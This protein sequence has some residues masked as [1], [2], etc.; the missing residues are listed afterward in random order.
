MHLCDPW[1]LPSACALRK[2][3]RNWFIWFFSSPLKDNFM[4]MKNA[5]KESFRGIQD[6][7]G[8]ELCSDVLSVMATVLCNLWVAWGTL[9]CAEQRG[10]EPET[11]SLLH[12]WPASP[13]ADPEM[14]SGIIR[15]HDSLGKLHPVTIRVYLMSSRCGPAAV[16]PSASKAKAGLLSLA[17]PM[18]QLLLRMCLQWWRRP[19]T[20]RT[21]T[22]LE[23]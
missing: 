10:C 23:I 4:L 11:S 7:L 3:W 9:T 12:L 18:A 2:K 8:K 22:V 1:P 16:H 5:S 15:V 6:L 14:P 19:S 13:L 17:G 20:V 21:G